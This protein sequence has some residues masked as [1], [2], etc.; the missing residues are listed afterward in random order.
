MATKRLNTKKLKQIEEI[1]FDMGNK[2]AKSFGKTHDIHSLR[3]AVTAYRCSMQAI[4]DQ[5]RYK[6]GK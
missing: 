6:I 5:I 1:T 2:S 3:A 4:R